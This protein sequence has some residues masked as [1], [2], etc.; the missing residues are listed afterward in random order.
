VGMFPKVNARPELPY[1]AI[2]SGHVLFDM[3]YN[4]MET[5]FIRAGMER[6]ATVSNGLE[7]LHGQAEAS[8]DIWNNP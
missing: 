7:M 8:W 4:P 6:G 1:G 3:V 2:G 5:A